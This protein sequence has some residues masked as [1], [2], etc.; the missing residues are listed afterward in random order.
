MVDEEERELEHWQKLSE[1]CLNVSSTMFAIIFSII[2]GLWSTAGKPSGSFSLG[3]FAIAL[4]YVVEALMC[5]FALY[6]NKKGVLPYVSMFAKLSV[7]FLCI[8]I[9]EMVFMLGYLL[10]M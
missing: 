10:F 3:F 8:I 7:L 6:G 5:I 1:V 4:T 2:F 9:A